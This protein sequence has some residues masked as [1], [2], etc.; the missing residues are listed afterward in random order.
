[1]SEVIAFVEKLSSKSGT[2]RLGRPYT[3]HSMKL[4]SADGNV[5]EGWFQLGFNAPTFR[6]GDYV[7]LEAKPKGANFE[8]V[9]GSVKVSKNPPAKPASPVSG[10]SGPVASSSGSGGYTPRAANVK[11]SELFGD[12]GGYNTED[13]IRRMSYSAARS[14]ALK[15]VELLLANDGLKLVKADSKA[16]SQA[17]FD[18][19]TEA[20]DKLTVEFF[21]DAAT[22]RKLEAVADSGTVT[23]G[24]DG[25]LPVSD[26]AESSDASDEGFEDTPTDEGE[27]DGFDF[28]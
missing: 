11:T 20:I 7:K 16:G 15:A 5:L 23:L 19:I 10:N 8:V 28:E 2:N 17:R 26:E 13:D 22:G 24:G 27:T 6:E 9:E 4:Q 25:P 21:F 12:I 1:M 18:L 3:L 14:D